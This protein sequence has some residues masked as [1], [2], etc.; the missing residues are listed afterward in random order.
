MT[1]MIPLESINKLQQCPICGHVGVNSVEKT[2]GQCPLCAVALML[3][4]YIAEDDEPEEKRVI[5]LSN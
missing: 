2:H 3:S 1:R 4:R 5:E